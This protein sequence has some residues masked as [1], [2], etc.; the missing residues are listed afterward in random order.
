MD[1]TKAKRQAVIDE[2]LS[3]TGA[4]MLVPDAFLS[5][6]RPQTDHDAHSWFFG[7][8]DGEA[9]WEYRL[10][11]VR[12]MAAGL[13][14]TVRHDPEESH[15]VSITVRDYPAYVSPGEN[16]RAG[17]GYLQFDPQDADQMA[18]LRRQGRVAMQSWI[19]RY[20]AAFAGVDL[21]AVLAIAEGERAA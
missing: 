20:A 10:N 11:L 5:W 15:V 1:F 21:G 17:G 14:I 6:L 9:A 19:N 2:Y 8:D 12:R 13:R 7:K 18:E 3:A 16:R 4:N